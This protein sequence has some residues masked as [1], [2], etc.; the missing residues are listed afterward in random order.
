[1]IQILLSD[2]SSDNFSDPS[3]FEKNLHVP[4]STNEPAI[5]D[6]VLVKFKT[7]S[8]KYYVGQIT[9]NKDMRKKH[10]VTE[11]FFPEVTALASVKKKDIRAVLPAPKECGSTSRQRSSLKFDYD[12]FSSMYINS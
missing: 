6:Y 5:G 10:N 9:K 1:M 8:R 2:H 4:D 7:F 12:F 3:D 11:F